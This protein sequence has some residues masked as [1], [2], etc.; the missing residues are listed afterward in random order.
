VVADGSKFDVTTFATIAPL[1]SVDSIVT[2]E[3]APSNVV[4]QIRKIG[5]TVIIAD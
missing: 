4:D 2:D 5:V 3:S 1:L